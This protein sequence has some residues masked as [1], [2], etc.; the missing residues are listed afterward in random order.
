MLPVLGG[1]GLEDLSDIW[2][3]ISCFTVHL[4]EFSQTIKRLNLWRQGEQIVGLQPARKPRVQ[5][6]ARRCLTFWWA[7]KDSNLGPAD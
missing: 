6:Q 5:L 2:Q 4:P 1:L 7:H 3:E